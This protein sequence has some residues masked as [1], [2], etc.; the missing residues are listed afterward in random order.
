[1]EDFNYLIE[2]EKEEIKSL[3]TKPIQFEAEQI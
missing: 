1:M 2:H 3:Q